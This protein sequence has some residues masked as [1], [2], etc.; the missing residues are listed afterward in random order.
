[1]RLDHEVYLGAITACMQAGR[2]EE[3]IGVLR[4]MPGE[5]V[6]PEVWAYNT[7]LAGSDRH[8]LARPDRM[9]TG[10]T[11]PRER[12]RNQR[13]PEALS[14]LEEMEAEGLQPDVVAYNAIIN[15]LRLG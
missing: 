7:I 14:L 12:W 15:S 2:W 6:M 13:W 10:A 9:G 5:G 3:A 8:P 11:Y 1:W 4:R